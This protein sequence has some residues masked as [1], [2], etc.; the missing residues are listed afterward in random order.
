M[1]VTLLFVNYSRGTPKGRK[2]DYNDKVILVNK[3]I[4]QSLIQRHNVTYWHDYGLWN[5]IQSLLEDDKVH[6][7]L[8]GIHVY[9]KNVTLVLFYCMSRRILI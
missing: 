1:F 8:E 2:L 4:K 7:N 5:N 3:S 6:L 9:T